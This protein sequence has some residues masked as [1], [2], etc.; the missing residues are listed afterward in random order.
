MLANEGPDVAPAKVDRRVAD[1]LVQVA[2]CGAHPGVAGQSL[3]VSLGE[4]VLD[5]VGQTIGLGGS[6]QAGTG[7]RD[8]VGGRLDIWTHVHSLL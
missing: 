2:L 8:T 4:G 7:G 5:L 6:R 3:C 1:H